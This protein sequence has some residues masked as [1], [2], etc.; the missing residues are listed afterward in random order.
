MIRTAFAG[1]A[2]ALGLTA[3]AG[4]PKKAAPPA[5][6]APEPATSAATAMPERKVSPY[7]PAQEDLAKRGHYV[8]GGLY[9]PHIADSAPTVTIDVAAI[10]EPDVV[11]LPRSRYGNRSPYAVLDRQY[12]VLADTRDYVEIGTA[13]YYGTKFHGRRTSNQEV[14]DMYA[15]SAAH[16]SLPLPSFA[17][18]TN[19][20]TGQSL[21]VRVNDRGPFHQGRLIDLSYAAAVKLGITRRGTGRVEV[22]ALQPD[23]AQPGAVYASAA[24]Q[25]V[26]S[27]AS[28]LASPPAVAAPSAVAALDVAV[29]AGRPVATSTLD[30]L[31]SS[32]PV[33]P[34][35]VI[36]TPPD[37]RFDMQQDGKPMAADEFEAWMRARRVRIATGRAGTP[38][39]TPPLASTPPPASAPAM[40][41]GMTP[42]MAPTVSPVVA[43]APMPAFAPVHRAIEATAASSPVTLQVASFAARANADRALSMLREAGIGDARLHDGEADGKVVY[44]LRVGTD[45]ARLAEMSSRIAGL[46]FGLP[47]RVRD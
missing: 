3:C 2:L 47:Q 24:V 15:F 12:T 1:L 38:D 18:V 43:S 35:P 34:P 37:Y 44:R 33:A 8:R 9:A 4:A 41:P 29:E 31:V 46:G 10:P 30:A 27:Q 19:L 23:G 28:R 20:D 5:I 39:A 36:A 32:M 21:I 11:Q 13:S 14:Y 40:A 22:R 6:A 7:A 26:T 45:A 25:P 17:R 16:R 42:G